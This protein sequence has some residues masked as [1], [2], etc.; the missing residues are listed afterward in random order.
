MHGGSSLSNGNLFNGNPFIFLLIILSLFIAG[1]TL[2]CPAKA[3]VI[4]ETTPP[5]VNILSFVHTDGINDKV[6]FDIYDLGG[7]SIASAA[8]YRDGAY[9]MDIVGPA[10]DVVTYDTSLLADGTY[11]LEAVAIDTVGNIATSSPLAMVI[12]PTAPPLDITP[13]HVTILSI[14]SNK[15]YTDIYDLGGSAIAQ[16]E[17]YIDGALNKTITPPTAYD[18]ITADS[19]IVTEG[20]HEAIVSAVDTAGN[21]AT[22]TIWAIYLDG[23]AP[24]LTID[25]IDDYINALNQVAGTITENGTG[26]ATTNLIIQNLTAS[27]YWNGE[28]WQSEEYLLPLSLGEGDDYAYDTSDV[29]FVSANQYQITAAATDNND[30]SDNALETFTFDNVAPTT[31]D[32]VPA[33]TQNADV[34]VTLSCAD[35]ASGCARAF[36]TTDGSDPTAGSTFVDASSSWQFIASTNGSY[37]IKYRGI[38][39]V[40]NLENIRTAAN[41]LVLSKSAGGGGVWLPPAATTTPT[42]T[43]EGQVLGVKIYNP[44]HNFIKVTGRPAVYWLSSDNT[45]HLFPSRETFS[46]WFGDDFSGLREISQAE[47]DTVPCGGNLTVKPGSYLKFDNS[48]IIYYA[49]DGNN[50]YS[51]TDTPARIYLIQA[52]FEGNYSINN[53]IID[54]SQIYSQINSNLIK[55]GEQSGVYW[56]SPDNKR[57]LFTNR[58]A[59]SSWFGDDFSGLKNISQEEFDAIVSGG[60]LTVKPGSYLKFD[61]SDITYHIQDTNNICK[62]DDVS[63]TAKT[64]L[65]Q[66]GFEADYSMIGNCQ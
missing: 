10:Y 53:L 26:I 51:T 55:A 46:S 63:T 38:D 5:H 40:G 29:T 9:V 59:F 50:I 58:E 21:R 62:S 56:L 12:G 60:N 57:Y 8:L 25:P 32:N 36:Y 15:I 44:D 34:T 1:I 27:Q 54:K 2:I 65:I 33:G 23:Q 4:I 66:A 19:S 39:N 18:L 48:D 17:L 11:Q 28:D 14:V 45:R 64:Y 61:N 52:G 7:S 35:D 13:P 31:T 3:G 6:Y 20:D 37:T 43:D 41:T 47:F 22:S 24:R 49:E 16:V 30:N 42:S